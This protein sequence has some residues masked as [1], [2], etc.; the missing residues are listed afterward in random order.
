MNEEM[1]FGAPPLRDATR[2]PND[3]E[4]G[5]Q[6]R[7]RLIAKVEPNRVYRFQD[8]PV[9]GTELIEQMRKATSVNGKPVL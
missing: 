7:D 2:L 4:T 1:D 8:G 5:A 6:A 9:T 3:E